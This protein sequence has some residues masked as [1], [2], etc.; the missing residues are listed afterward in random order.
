MKL[1][2]GLARL[3]RGEKMSDGE[4]SA[5]QQRARDLERTID[6]LG[7]WMTPTG[8]VEPDFFPRFA[9]NLSGLPLGP[10]M[11]DL[12]SSMTIADN[13]I[14]AATFGTEVFNFGQF[15]WSSATSTA[16]FVTPESKANLLAAIAVCIFDANSSGVRQMRLRVSDVD[17]NDSDNVLSGVAAAPGVQTTLTGATLLP[18]QTGPNNKAISKISLLLAQTSGGNLGLVQARLGLFRVY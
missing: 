7:V 14:T 18:L 17:G 6:K 4:A 15:T 13:T 9:A 16:I 10:A 3:A 8:D 1:S 12:A 5:F 2:D 11:Y